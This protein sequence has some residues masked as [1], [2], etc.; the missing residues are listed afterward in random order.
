MKLTAPINSAVQFGSDIGAYTRIILAMIIREAQS[1]IASPF[2]SFVD[3]LEPVF[4]IGVTT[5]A[6]WMLGRNNLAPLGTSPILFYA[7]G[8]FFV[9]LFIHQSNRMRRSVDAPTR[10]FPVERRLDAIFVHLL[11]KIIEY[12]VLG[13]IVFGLI[14][15]FAT[16][17]AIPDDWVPIV[18]AVVAVTMLSF[19]WGMVNVTLSRVSRVWAMLFAPFN[20]GFVIFSGVVFLADFISPV[21]RH[22]ISYNPLVHAVALFRFGFYPNHPTFV[23][24]RQYLALCAIV[25]VAMGLTIERLSRRRE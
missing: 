15:A 12:A 25:A 19:G 8:F 21:A 18:L 5:M 2:S 17:D 20:R 1:R 16:T 13:V 7:T 9:Y 24:D 11:F 23:L 3:L 22:V 6:W 14:A 4:L 10:R